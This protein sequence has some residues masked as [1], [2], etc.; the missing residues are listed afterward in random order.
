M[1]KVKLRNIKCDR[2]DT[3]LIDNKG[4]CVSNFWQELTQKAYDGVTDICHYFVCLR[5]FH[6]FENELHQYVEVEQK[7]REKNDSKEGRP[8]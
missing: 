8:L 2:C 3:L 5:C 7:E 4:E 1:S 6:W